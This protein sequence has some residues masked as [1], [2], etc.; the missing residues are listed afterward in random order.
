MLLIKEKMEV[1]EPLMKVSLSPEKRLLSM[2]KTDLI[3]R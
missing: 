1:E 3:E 2:I